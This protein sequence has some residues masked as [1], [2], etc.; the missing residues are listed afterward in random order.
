M[1]TLDALR[2]MF[3]DDELD[4]LKSESYPSRAAIVRQ[5]RAA[6]DNRVDEVAPLTTKG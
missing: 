2:G 6:V 5:I 3:L 4:K 1:A